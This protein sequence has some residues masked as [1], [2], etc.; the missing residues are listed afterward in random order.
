MRENL[1]KKHED[2]EEE[3]RLDD[4]IDELDLDD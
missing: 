2:V 3:D 4:R 1:S